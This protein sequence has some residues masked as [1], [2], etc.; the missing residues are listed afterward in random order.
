MSLIDI[1]RPKKPTNPDPYYYKTYAQQKGKNYRITRRD[2][3]DLESQLGASIFGAP[4]NGETRRFFNLDDN[5]WMWYEEKIDASGKK[6]ETSV[7][8][9]ITPDKVIK[10]EP[11]PYYKAIEGKELENFHRAVHAYHR[12]V[13][14]RIYGKSV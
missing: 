11:G 5:T 10:I 6:S 14:S 1:I 2:L 4:S 12:I 8:Y 13:L 7:R 9:E 3:L